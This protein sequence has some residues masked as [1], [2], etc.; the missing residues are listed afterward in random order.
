MKEK[1]A[2]I[3]SIFWLLFVS[4]GTES[5][6]DQSSMPDST[7]TITQQTST[8]VV[9]VEAQVIKLQTIEENI[10]LTGVLQPIRS[11]DIVAEISGEIVQINKNLGKYVTL[12]DTLA[13]IDDIIPLTN[14][15]Q[16]RSQVLQTE[17]NLKISQLN[18]KSDKDLFQNGDI[19]ELAYENSLLNVKTAEA[20]HLSALANL[21]L[22]EKNYHETRIKTPIPG[23]I[24]RK[25]V[26]LGT[27][28]TPNMP[29]YR[30]VDLSALKIEV[31]IPQ[32]LIDRI[33][34]GSYAKIVISALNDQAF[35]GEVR[36][37][38][39]QADENTGAFTTEIHVKNI[40]NLKI[41]AGMTA[42]IELVLQDI[43][44][45]IAIPDYA[46]VSRKEENYIYKIQNNVARIWKIEI[47]GS[48]GSKIF[49]RSGISEGDTI[50]VVGMKNL[51]EETNVWIEQVHKN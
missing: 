42:K 31:G 33:T 3:F 8:R 47:G 23:L 16:A 1:G 19:S 13:I 26:E 22:M 36:Y 10:P 46:I 25:Y 5:S 27:M 37:I 41:K 2:C 9:P 50:V 29:V 34:I 40:D 6:Q 28:V 15:Q 35:D 17:A 48:F 38:S 45:R 21:S 4:C 11:V 18:L 51:G 24:S 20:N 39:P 14:Y 49:V 30:V 44:N 7:K 12:A 43:S 32:T